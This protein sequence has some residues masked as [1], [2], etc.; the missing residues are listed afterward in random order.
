MMQ[1][2]VALATML[3]QSSEPAL[4]GNWRNPRGSVIISFAP[5][6]EAMCGRVQW[7]SDKAIADARKGGTDPLIGIELLRDFVPKGEGRWKGRIFLPDLN[8]TSKAEL[9]QL[10]PDQVKVSG[11]AVGRIICKSQVWTRAEAN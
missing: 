4:E 5:C 1:L 2:L 9:R 8:R 10:G 11:C 3:V 7:A 6:A